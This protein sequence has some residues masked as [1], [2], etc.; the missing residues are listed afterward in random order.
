MAS[1]NPFEDQKQDKEKGSCMGEATTNPF[2]QDKEKQHEEEDN[3]DALGVKLNAAYESLEHMRRLNLEIECEALG[4][5]Y[6]FDDEESNQQCVACLLA[7]SQEQ[8][9]HQQHQQDD[10]SCP[11]PPPPRRRVRRSL[12]KVIQ[13]GQSRLPRKLQVRA[14]VVPRPCLICGN[15]TCSRHTCRTLPFA[16]NNAQ[17]SNNHNRNNNNNHHNITLCCDCE[18][19]FQSTFLITCLTADSH[20]Q[21]QALVDHL[22][23]LYDRTTLLLRYAQNTNLIQQ[24][25]DNLRQK[26]ARQNVRGVT[27]STAGMVSGALGVA[28]A[29]T[30]WTPAGPPLLIASVLMASS[31]QAVHSHTALHNRFVS[32]SHAVANNLLGLYGVATTIAQ[33][34]D[35]LR[36]VVTRDMVY[37]ASCLSER[38]A[39]RTLMT[40]SASTTSSTA[41]TTTTT[42]TS[43]SHNQRTAKRNSQNIVLLNQHLSRARPYAYMVGQGIAATRFLLEAKNMHDTTKA[44]YHGNR[45]DKAHALERIQEIMASSTT[46]P[47]TANLDAQLTSVYLA[48]FQ[49]ERSRSMTQ[50]QAVQLLQEISQRQEESEQRAQARGVLVVV[51]GEESSSSSS[52]AIVQHSRN[53]SKLR[54]SLPQPRPSGTLSNRCN[55]M[56]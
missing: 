21:R 36:D 9:Q 39:T 25:A 10:N 3:N 27:G 18:T 38:D 14:R 46:L 26:K 33:L 45:C 37:R 42:T 40:R 20:R 2:E 19:L 12:Q 54:W 49:Q 22:L 34:A 17:A 4:I 8:H 32:D 56:G 30:I 15:P 41:L 1:T 28:A 11:K 13:K 24:T 6:I 53:K 23:H 50:D 44:I 51:N 55:S 35:T 48:H 29:V 47:T 16:S 5:P 7:T 31:A 43:R 52:T